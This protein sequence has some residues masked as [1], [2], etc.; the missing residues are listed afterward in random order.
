MRIDMHLHTWYSPDGVSPPEKIIQTVRK[1]REQ[2]L[3]DGIAVTDHNMVK[4]WKHFKNVDFPVVFG[5]EVKSTQGDILCLFLNEEIKSR[6]PGEVIDEV[7]GQG[8][9]AVFP[10]PFDIYRTNFKIPQEFVKSIDGIEVFNSRMKTPSG[11]TQALEFAK[12]HSLPMTG[13]SD[14]HIRF[15]IGNAYTEGE[16]GDLDEFRKALEEGKTRGLG[17][18]STLWVL[19][20]VTK[21]AIWHLIGAAP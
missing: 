5:E 21:L 13:G 10:H 15:S 18:H 11:N 16:A 9:L 4:A 8:G 12:K 6:E 19:V 2:G 7:H 1:K 20:P 14:A 3:L 17:K